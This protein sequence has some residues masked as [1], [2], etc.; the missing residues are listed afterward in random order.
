[1]VNSNG[2]GRGGHSVKSS[3]LFSLISLG[4]LSICQDQSSKH[5]I[6]TRCVKVHQAYHPSA[7]VTTLSALCQKLGWLMNLSCTDDACGTPS[8]WHNFLISEAMDSLESKW[9]KCDLII[10]PKWYCACITMV[11]EDDCAPKSD[12][13]GKLFPIPAST[14]TDITIFMSPLPIFIA[15]SLSNKCDFNGWAKRDRPRKNHPD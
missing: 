3:P 5:L 6:I 7:L 14:S 1:M 11:S 8:V 9:C 10:E 2:H 4:H 12:Q 15:P 13:V